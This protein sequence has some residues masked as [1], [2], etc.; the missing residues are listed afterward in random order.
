MF[1]P[2]FSLVLNEMTSFLCDRLKRRRIKFYFS[3]SEEF[4]SSKS[5]ADS[6]EDAEK[7]KVGFIQTYYVEFNSNIEIFIII[8]SIR[9]VL[10]RPYKADLAF[11]M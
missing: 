11:H 10:I 2:G 4:Y 1:G 6:S 8:F 5:V 9:R 3:A 7:S